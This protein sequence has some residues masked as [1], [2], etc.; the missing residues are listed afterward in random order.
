MIART[1]DVLKEFAAIEK[2]LLSGAASMKELGKL[3]KRH[4]ALKP[5]VDKIRELEKIDSGIHQARSLLKSPDKELV[6]LAE[7]ELDDLKKLKPRLESDI[8]VLLLPKD[9]RDSKSVFM[10]IRAGAGGEEAALF[11]AELV[12][13]YTRFAQEMGWKVQLPEFSSSGRKG[14]RQATLF[15]KGN[16]VYSWMRDEGGVHRVQRVPLTESSGR[17]HTST[18]TVAVMPEAE[19]VEIVVNPKD[20]KIDTYRAGGAGGQNVNKVETA[21][22][23]THVPSGIVVQCQQERSQGQNREKAM[24][25]LRAKL[26][27]AAEESQNK[28]IA[29]E[30]RQQVGTG[31]RSEKIRTYNFPQNRV[32]D[33]R[34]NKS[35][36]NL[37]AVMDGNFSAILETL[38]GERRTGKQQ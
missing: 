23:I 13:A 11:A 26:A 6:S 28:S 7:S 4:A 27:S 17:I 16:G 22:R 25:I 8:N 1:L 32:T 10:E 31:D 24:K 34:L 20:L 14:C 37:Q 2:K 19:D 21:V 36:H 15:I 9:A 33:H 3:S 35:W 30:R 5:V 18:C 12:R 29:Q 38:R